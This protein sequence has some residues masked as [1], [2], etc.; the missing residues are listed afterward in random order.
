M[1]G[2]SF[3]GRR[4]VHVPNYGLNA[5]SA[6]SFQIDCRQAHLR[7]AVLVGLV[8]PPED[9]RN[10][11]ASKDTLPSILRPILELAM[12]RLSSRR[13]RSLLAQLLVI[14]YAS[15]KKRH[16]SSYVVAE[17]LDNKLE[18]PHCDLHEELC[19]TSRGSTEMHVGAP[20][21]LMEVCDIL[22]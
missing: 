20:P 3:E 4:H 1:L 14:V 15:N 10:H 17:A 11:P 2:Q 6:P 19:P 21:L 8:A 7:H 18:V 16:P 13:K 9:P 12:P 22:R 5:S